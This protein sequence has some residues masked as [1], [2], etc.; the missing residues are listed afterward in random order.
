MKRLIPYIA[1]LCF[2]GYTLISGLPVIAGGCSYH[3]N[4]S[5]KINCAEDDTECQIE[6]NENFDLK[7]TVKS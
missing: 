3:K 2:T 5:V 4:K 6:K 1:F 7:K